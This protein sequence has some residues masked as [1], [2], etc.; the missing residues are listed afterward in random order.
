MTPNLL[1]I[2]IILSLNYY[3]KN[4]NFQKTLDLLENIQSIK[5]FDIHSLYHLLKGSNGITIENI[6]YF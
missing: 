3:I 4:Y 5:D 2:L 1:L 6:K